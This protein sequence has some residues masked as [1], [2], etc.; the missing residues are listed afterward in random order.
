[1]VKEDIITLDE[2]LNKFERINGFL[3]QKIIYG[4]EWYQ[5]K[6][7]YAN[8]RIVTPCKQPKCYT[9]YDFCVELGD[10]PR[11]RIDITDAFDVSRITIKGDSVNNEFL[12]FKYH[13]SSNTSLA[14]RD[15]MNIR[16]IVQLIYGGV[17]ERKNYERI[18]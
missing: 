13:G 12:A 16:F 15:T 8:R 3:I 7:L 14:V 4:C 2:K 9:L 6:R 18:N 1:M 17:E 11:N 5:F 10:V